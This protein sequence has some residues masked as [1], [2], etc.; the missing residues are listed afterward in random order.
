MD[1]SPLGILP[2]A[3]TGAMSF[4]PAA[5]PGGGRLKISSWPRGEWYD[6]T[7]AADGSGTYDLTSATYINTFQGGPEGFIYVPHGSPLFPGFNLLMAE[8]SDGFVAAY[9]VDANGDP[10]Q[11]SRQDFIIGLTGAEGAFIRS[12]D[13]R[14]SVFDIWNRLGHDHRSA[15][16]QSANSRARYAA[17]CRQWYPDADSALEE[18][19]LQS[20]AIQLSE[21]QGTE[22]LCLALF[23]EAEFYRIDTSCSFVA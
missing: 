9:Q 22:S 1:L 17:A 12:A 14:L 16:F 6:V 21:P 13:R 3:S 5:F 7:F 10:I 23:Y 2:S 4:V 15:G 11:A 18:V 8:F 19:V 20:I